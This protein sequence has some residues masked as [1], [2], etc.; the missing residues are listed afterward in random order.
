MIIKNTLLSLDEHPTAL[1]NLLLVCR[2]PKLCS[3]GMEKLTGK[4]KI[5]KSGF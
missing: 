1:Y 4:S 5:P 2:K 3:F